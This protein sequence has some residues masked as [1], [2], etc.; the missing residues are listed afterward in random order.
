MIRCVPE[1]IFTWD[2]RLDGPGLSARTE[3]GGWAERGAIRLDGVD[4][5]VDKAGWF[6]GRWT[7]RR[8]GEAVVDARRRGL[9]SST[10]DLSG[11]GGAAAL[12]A[13]SLFGRAMRLDG[14]AFR[15]TIEP[16]HPFTRRATIDGSFSDALTVCMA[17]WLAVLVWRRADAD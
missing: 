3:L 5:R 14:A 11:P 7:M 1:S 8:A 10:F 13:A 9:L 2:F 4:Y 17:F 12:S 6:A 16:D 15:C